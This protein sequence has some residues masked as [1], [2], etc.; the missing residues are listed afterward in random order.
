TEG[1]NTE[2]GEHTEGG[3]TEEGEHTE[4]GN[5]DVGQADGGQ[6]GQEDLQY[7]NDL[8]HLFNVRDI[9]GVVCSDHG[10]YNNEL[11][12]KYMFWCKSSATNCN[13]STKQPTDIC[14]NLRGI[15]IGA[16]TKPE[17]IGNERFLSAT[18]FTG[19]YKTDAKYL[20]YRTNSKIGSIGGKISVFNDNFCATLLSSYQIMVSQNNKYS[21]CLKNHIL[22]AGIE[23]AGNFRFTDTIAIVPDFHA[24][25]SFISTED[26]PSLRGGTISCQNLN[27]TNLCAGINL[28]LGDSNCGG[29]ISAHINKRLGKE[30]CGH[31]GTSKFSMLEH[32]R[33]TSEYA[34]GI[35][36]RNKNWGTVSLEASRLTG[37]T[38]GSSI[39]LNVSIDV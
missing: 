30:L 7:L 19:Y 28:E 16:D 23:L 34:I 25:Y 15:I 6:D 11:L 21:A 36:V 29:H 8:F 3:N 38:K 27:R 5:P 10:Q 37:G 31:S 20:D 24:D 13:F 9:Y 18:L 39:K 26:F 35:R 17:N 4:G 2:E 32:S 33:T 1:G 14:A 22:S 12:G